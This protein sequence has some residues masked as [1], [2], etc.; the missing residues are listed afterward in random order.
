M[1]LQVGTFK[2]AN[3]RSHIQS[4]LFL[5]LTHIVTYVHPL[6]VVVLKLE[7][8]LQEDDFTELLSV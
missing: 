6:Q 1:N 3:M 7:L 2:E 8:K 4:R 5:C